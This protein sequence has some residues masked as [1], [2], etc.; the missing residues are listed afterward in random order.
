MRD[1][2]RSDVIRTSNCDIRDDEGVPPPKIPDD[3]PYIVEGSEVAA[4]IISVCY[5]S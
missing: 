2:R 3:F 1:L 4:H 5:S